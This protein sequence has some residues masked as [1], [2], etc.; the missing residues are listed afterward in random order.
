MSP[1]TPRAG[2]PRLLSACC[3]VS[4]VLL[5]SNCS[6]RGLVAPPEASPEAPSFVPAALRGTV[7]VQI[8][9]RAKL[10]ENGDLLVTVRI[11]CPEGFQ[12]RESGL[13][14]VTQGLATA[15]GDP[16]GG[17]QCTGHWEQR[18]VRLFLISAEEVFEPGPAE[19]SFQFEA[20]NP[21]TEVILSTSV[22]TAVTIR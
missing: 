16:A 6:E 18:K 20:E 10:L 3:A 11:L 12:R 21:V 5:L 1:I 8:R 14:A 17:D 2:L 22:R 15:E 4:L 19:A 9:D 7:Q 13:L